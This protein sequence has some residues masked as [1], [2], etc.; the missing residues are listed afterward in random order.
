MKRMAGLAEKNRLDQ[1]RLQNKPIARGPDLLRVERLHREIEQETAR[2]LNLLRTARHDLACAYDKLNSGL[3]L[4]LY[5]A[6]LER[7]RENAE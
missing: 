4:E 6:S 3:A 1:S 2:I 7:R 5:A